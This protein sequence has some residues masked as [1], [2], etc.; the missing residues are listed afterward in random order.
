MKHR[1]SNNELQP[2]IPNLADATAV[3]KLTCQHL[4]ILTNAKQPLQESLNVACWLPSLQQITVANKGFCQRA[5]ETYLNLL[6]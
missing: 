4:W 5:E 1:E 3:R 6:K 2:Q